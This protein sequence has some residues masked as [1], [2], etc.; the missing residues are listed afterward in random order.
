MSKEMRKQ[1]NKVKNFETFSNFNEINKTI[2]GYIKF[3]LNLDN[4]INEFVPNT[5]IAEK[6][7]NVL[8]YSELENNNQN[9]FDNVK[10]DPYDSI[11]L[12]N[13]DD[14][15]RLKDGRY[16][17]KET[18]SVGINNMLMSEY[19]D[20]K[21]LKLEGINEINIV[22]QKLRRNV[23]KVRNNIILGRIVLPGE[24]TDRNSTKSNK[25]KIK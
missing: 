22:Y 3:V 9:V 5:H 1:I 19:F 13:P 25:I 16:L 17:K 21:R 15:D 20:L 24:Y 8:I 14:Y 18:Y 11:G 12:N 7:K 4:K 23:D 2:S 10:H 6:F